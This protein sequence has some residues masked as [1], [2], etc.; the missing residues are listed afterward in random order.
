MEGSA[1]NGIFKYLEKWMFLYTKVL[2]TNP[3]CSRPEPGTRKPADMTL[4]PNLGR[5]VRNA[6]TDVPRSRPGTEN[7]R[8]TPAACPGA[9]G[10]DVLRCRFKGVKPL[11]P[12]REWLAF[13]GKAAGSPFPDAGREADGRPRDVLVPGT[14]IELPLGRDTHRTCLGGARRTQGTSGAVLS[15][16][17]SYSGA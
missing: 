10:H 12:V 17:R 13:G 11:F 6:M 15:T 2:L 3:C 7:A 4:G 1:T 9:L 14:A 8:T 5:T 16:A